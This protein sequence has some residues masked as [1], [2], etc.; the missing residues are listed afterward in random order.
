MKAAIE[1]LHALYSRSNIEIG[2]FQ[3]LVHSMYE[4]DYLDV[5]QK[6]YEWSVVGPEDIDDTRYMISKKISEVRRTG[7]AVECTA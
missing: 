7:H 4:T 6:L 2:S 3:P 5:L 1:A